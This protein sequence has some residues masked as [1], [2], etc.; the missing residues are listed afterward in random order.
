[1]TQQVGMKK[2]VSHDKPDAAVPYIYELTN[3]H[4]K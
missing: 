3:F 1:M 2:K 4:W